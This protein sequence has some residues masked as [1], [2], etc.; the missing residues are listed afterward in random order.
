MT[1]A[2]GDTYVRDLAYRSSFVPLQA[3][4]QLSYVAARAGFAPPDPAL[5]FR[6][7]EFGCGS[8]VTLNALAA[9]CP[10][11]QF[12]GVDFNA[13]SIAEACSEA[14]RAGLGNV[15]YLAEAFSA[16]DAARFAPADYVACAGTWSWLDAAEKAALTGLLQATLRPGGLLL[17]GFVT[18]GRAAVTPMWEALRAL[19]PDAG[20]GSMPRVKAGIR[21]LAALR[22]HGA[23]YLEQNASA[24]A[25]LAE[26]QAH[27][28]RG[29]E[30]ALQNVSHNLLAAGFRQQLLSEVA[31]ELAPAGLQFCGAAA[32]QLNDPDFAVPAA[33]RAHYDA[34]PGSV[35]KAVFQDFLDATISRADVFISRAA[36]DAT[37][38]A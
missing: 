7:V 33:L 18:I 38:A 13:A 16:L 9:A 2:F 30:R 21:L 26:V 27:L 32:A 1:D 22:D 17:L 31:A 10:Q 3:P 24:S 29:D 25:L 12:I 23:R 28:E 37:S 35:A 8:G 5:A 11:G 14:T 6:Y 36:A 4:A 34:L 15:T 20:Q 19:V